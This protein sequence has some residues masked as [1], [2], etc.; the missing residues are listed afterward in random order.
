METSSLKT[1]KIMRRNLDENGMFMNFAP[2]QPR[3]TS[4][5]GPRTDNNCRIILHQDFQDFLVVIYELYF[6]FSRE[7]GGGALV[8]TF[9]SSPVPC[10]GIPQLVQYVP[11][12]GIYQ[13]KLEPGDRLNK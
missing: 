8:R 11:H 13:R 4:C 5:R 3:K 9:I 7:W 1:L 2:A 10:M 12:K 6:L